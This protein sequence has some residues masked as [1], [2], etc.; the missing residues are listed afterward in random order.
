[1]ILA[2]EYRL[3][4]NAKREDVKEEFEE[5]MEELMELK[6]EV[7][8]LLA[9]E[10]TVRVGSADLI[11]VTAKSTASLKDKETVRESGTDLKNFIAMSTSLK[12]KETVR[13][14]GTDLKNFFSHV[15]LFERKINCQRKWH[16]YH[17]CYRQ[18]YFFY[19]I[20][21]RGQ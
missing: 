2:V 14:S 4:G 19:K 7:D 3:R 11:K 16:G 6:D 20:C 15:Y 8:K 21:R 9:L 12:E 18:V 13:E 1:M 17:K 10:E 5:R